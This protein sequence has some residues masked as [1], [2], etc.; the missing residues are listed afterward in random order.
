MHPL[1]MAFAAHHRLPCTHLVAA[2]LCAR[3]GLLPDDPRHWR[4]WRALDPALCRAVNIE[5][6]GDRWSGPPI[7]ALRFGAAVEVYPA[8]APLPL[9]APGSWWYVQR[10]WGLDG[11]N[12]LGHAY[13]VHGG[14]TGGATVHDSRERR[15]YRATRQTQWVPAGCAWQQVRIG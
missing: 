11:E 9:L 7:A 12:P 4:D 15:G 14:P 10:W 6:H 2:E 5:D 3:L 13:L 1:V 8:N